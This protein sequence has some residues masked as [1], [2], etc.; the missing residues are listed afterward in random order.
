MAEQPANRFRVEALIVI[1]RGQLQFDARK[2]Q[3]GERVIGPRKNRLDL[4]GIGPIT[5]IARIGFSRIVFENED[6]FKQCR[7]IRHFAPALNVCERGMLM[8]AGLYRIEL[9][10]FQPRQQIGVGVYL[11]TNRN[12]VDE[13]S[14]C[15]L[16][17]CQLVRPHRNR[18]AKHNIIR[19]AIAT[20]QQCP[21]ALHER[22]HRQTILACECLQ[23]RSGVN[24][25]SQFLLVVSDDLFTR[26]GRAL[27]NRERSWRGEIFQR[28]L[29]KLFSLT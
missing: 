18:G 9:N 14:R 29:P 24:R 8:F 13:K 10:L 17:V 1:D 22:E 28:L 11:R 19:A 2:R 3:Q 16:D 21:R 12:G 5:E 20:Q 23:A 4:S 25:E 26:A 27:I 15:R 7:A 6:A